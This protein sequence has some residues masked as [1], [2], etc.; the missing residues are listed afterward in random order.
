MKTS[1]HLTPEQVTICKTY[2]YDDLSTDPDP[3]H[4]LKEA[5]KRPTP[6]DQRWEQ[7]AEW[8]WLSPRF[9]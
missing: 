9:N 6:S 7:L 5:E 8:I 3:W 1:D 4:A 2:Y